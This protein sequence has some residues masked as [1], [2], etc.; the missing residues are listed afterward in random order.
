MIATNYTDFSFS[1]SFCR[2][3]VMSLS[4]PPVGEGLYRFLRVGLYASMYPVVA[5]KKLV[6]K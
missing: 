2:R 6:E 1:S 5:P 3:T 4:P